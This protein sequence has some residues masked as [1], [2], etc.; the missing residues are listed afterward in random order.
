MQ[1]LTP[2]ERSDWDDFQSMCNRRSA[3][4]RPALTELSPQVRAAYGNYDRHWRKP[5]AESALKLS[6]EQADLLRKN[7]KLL[8]AGRPFNHL[9]DELLALASNRKCPMCGQREVAA[10]DHYLPK[11]IF[12]EFS[13]LCRNLVPVCSYCNQEKGDSLGDNVGHRFLHAY[14]DRLPEVELLIADVVIDTSVG[15]I[16]RICPPPEFSN[17]LIE[18]LE[19]HFDALKLAEYYM[20]EAQQELSDRAGTFCFQ[21]SSNGGEQALANL[22]GAEAR[23]VRRERGINNWKVA[24]YNS[25]ARSREFCSSGFRLLGRT[26]D[27]DYL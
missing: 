8:D 9:R 15:V 19:F 4:S 21:Y 13:A 20:R 18:H 17:P 3:A 22:L 10:L 27:W 7:Y 16:F 6:S 2:L 25:L 11:S 26:D 12:P 1:P 24:L 23:S 14:Y 5:L